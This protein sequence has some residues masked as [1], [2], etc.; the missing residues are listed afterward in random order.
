MLKPTKELEEFIRENLRYDP[1]TGCLWWT[2]PSESKKGRRRLDKPAGYIHNTRGYVCLHLGLTNGQVSCF[3]HR[4]A[5]FLHYGSWPKGLLDHIDGAKDNNKIDNLREAT[6]TQ[7]QR[8]KKKKNNQSSKYKGVYWY[9]GRQKWY[10]QIR[11]NYKATRLGGY[12]S[13]EEAAR[14]Y[15]KA[16]REYFGE[17][18]CLNFPEEH[19]QGATHGHD[20]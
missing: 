14:A 18:A 1:K 13:E 4:I 2:K 9:K 17:F 19:E 16:A 20:V 12:T 8:N 3:A 15:D 7:N 10:S 6:N 11:S 5:W